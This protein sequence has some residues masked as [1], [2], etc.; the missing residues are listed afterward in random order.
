[1]TIAETIKQVLEGKPEGLSAIEIYR[2]I[3]RKDLYQ[4]GAK[5]P[6][7]VVNCEIRRRC[8]SLNFPS[9]HPIKW[10][11]IVSSEG[12]HNNYALLK[13]KEN[14]GQPNIQEIAVDVSAD[15]L[16]EEKVIGAVKEHTEQIQKDLLSC[17]MEKEPSFFEHLVVDLLINMGYGYDRDSGVVTGRPHDNGIDGIIYEDKLGLD[18]IYIQAK[19]YAMNNKVGLQELQAFV[20]ALGN[21]QKGV[22]IT[23]SSFTKEAYTYGTTQ[24]QKHVRLIDGNLLCEFMVKYGVGVK[25][26]KEIYIYKID[27]E[28]FG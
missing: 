6:I 20:G 26:A 15:I 14:G 16:P 24:Q 5:Q 21:V 13:Y 9:A 8:D 22:F 23:T 17:I 2:E 11:Y 3:K 10:F 4:F 12:R 18:S 7:S 28:Y 19:R 25:V 27:E 1:M